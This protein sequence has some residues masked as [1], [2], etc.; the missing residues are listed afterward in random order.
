M[1]SITSCHLNSKKVNANVRCHRH[2]KECNLNEYCTLSCR[3]HERWP[4]VPLPKLILPVVS[5]TECEDVCCKRENKGCIK[6]DHIP[7]PFLRFNYSTED[8]D[9]DKK[10][11]LATY[12]TTTNEFHG[13]N[14]LLYCQGLDK[15]C[16]METPRFLEAFPMHCR[17]IQRL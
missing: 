16:N 4:G 5:Q 14:T 10:S 9:Y 1:E 2:C 13:R 6:C 8:G 17:S 11:N 15:R 7:P 12:Q 3:C